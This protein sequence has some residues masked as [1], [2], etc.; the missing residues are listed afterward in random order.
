[1]YNDYYQKPG[2]GKKVK[3][4]ENLEFKDETDKMK[5]YFQETVKVKQ[6]KLE[7]SKT[8]DENIEV[9]YVNSNYTICCV[10]NRFRSPKQHSQGMLK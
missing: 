3:L 8:F 2:S 10:R 9:E 6:E 1:M 4:E 5:R 7:T